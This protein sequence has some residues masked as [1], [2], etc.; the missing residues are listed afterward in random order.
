[1]EKRTKRTI[2]IVVAVIVGVLV[3]AGILIAKLFEGGL[4]HL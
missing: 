1:M 3:L 4:I 2:W